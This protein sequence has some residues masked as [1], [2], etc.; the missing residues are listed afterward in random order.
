MKFL[1]NECYWSIRVYL[2]MWCHSIINNLLVLHHWKTDSLL[3][4]NYTWTILGECHNENV[5]YLN[6][7][8]NIYI[9]LFLQNWIGK[10]GLF[11]NNYIWCVRV[12]KW[13]VYWNSADV[14]V[15]HQSIKTAW[16]WQNDVYIAEILPCTI[17]AFVNSGA[18][19]RVYMHVCL[20]SHGSA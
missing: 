20:F 12:N 17:F 18:K 1:L 14:H 3:G 8:A 7:F 16:R 2:E 4:L 19:K 11:A 13:M 6:I 9:S 5:G 15:W 10:S